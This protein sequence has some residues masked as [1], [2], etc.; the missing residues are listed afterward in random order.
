VR[1]PTNISDPDDDVVCG[2]S[3]LRSLYAVECHSP[4]EEAGSAAQ[5][6]MYWFQNVLVS[7][8]PD[9]PISN[10]TEAAMANVV[11]FGLGKASLISMR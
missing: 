5:A 3:E 1:P 2:K 9:V 10:D 4:G 6:S 11:E 7:L 8:V